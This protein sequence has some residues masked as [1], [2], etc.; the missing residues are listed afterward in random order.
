MVL[1]ASVTSYSVKN[2]LYKLFRSHWGES[3]RKGWMTYLQ[4]SPSLSIVFLVFRPFKFVYL[5][6]KNT[7]YT[8]ALSRVSPMLPRKGEEDTD[9]IM[10]SWSDRRRKFSK[11]VQ[12]Y[13]ILCMVIAVEDGILL[14]MK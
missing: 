6:G 14:K 10:Q 2:S 8:D 13:W 12:P 3:M 4:D 9:I 11:E 1:N 7:C 5:E